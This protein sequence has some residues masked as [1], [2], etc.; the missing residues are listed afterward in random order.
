MSKARITYRFESARRA[1]GQAAPEAKPAE[2]RAQRTIQSKPQGEGEENAS[3]SNVIPLRHDEFRLS[4]EDTVVIEEV[5]M[6]PDSTA[7]DSEPTAGTVEHNERSVKDYTFL[8]SYTY[9]YGAWNHPTNEEVERLERII[10]QTDFAPEKAKDEHED[11]QRSEPRRIRFDPEAEETEEEYGP[12]NAYYQEQ[13]QR[14]SYSSGTG[15]YHE[16]RT[17]GS[18][19]KLGASVVGAIATGVLFGSFVLNLFT[20]SGA[21][22]GNIAEPLQ[23][24]QSVP[25]S[26]AAGGNTADGAGSV[27]TGGAGGGEALSPGDAEQPQLADSAED[28]AGTVAAIHIPER[29]LYL[30]QNGKFSTLENARALANEMKSKGLAATIE[31]SGSFWVYAGVTSDRDA[32]LR[33]SRRLQDAGIEVFIKK[34]SLPAVEQVRWE[35]GASKEASALGEYLTQGSAMVRMI[36]DLTLVHLDGGEPVAPGKAAIDKVLGDHRSLTQLTSSA[37]S[38]LPADA[39]PILKRMDAAISTAVTAVQEY[40]ANPDRAYLWSA[41]NAIMDYI[42][43]EKQLLTDIAWQ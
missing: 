42:I 43:A 39:Q 37:Q 1:A 17:G 40:A 20:G 16:P 41:Q 10:R 3:R 38:G 12:H 6:L 7:D 27:V 14:R 34:Y 15:V 30:L 22:G 33:V 31:E 8:N 25:V 13:Q 24:E 23:G 11:Q 5:R 32:A 2:T 35:D 18:W 21:G 4:P 26:E 9:D 28:G 36:G 19:W 29:E